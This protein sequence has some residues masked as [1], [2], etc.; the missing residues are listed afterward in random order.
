MQK[1]LKG[2]ETHRDYVKPAVVHSQ[3]DKSCLGPIEACYFGPEVAVMHAK[4]TH[5]G[6][7]PWKLVIL[8][9]ITV[10]CM[11]KTTGYAWDP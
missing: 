5:E 7:D 9:L 6:W 11:H 3:N 8:M 1:Q 4:T 10:F 2:A